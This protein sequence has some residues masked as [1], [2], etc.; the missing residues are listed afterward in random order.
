MHIGF[1]TGPGNWET[2]RR[3]VIEDAPPFCELWFNILK[4]EE[5]QEM[6]DWLVRH[7]VKIGLH[8]WGLCRDSIKTNLATA[9]ADIRAESIRQVKATI[10]I[11]AQIN[12]V[13]VNAHPGAGY[14]EKMDFDTRTQSRLSVQA[15]SPSRAFFLLLE[16]AR[17]LHNYA[18]D[19]GVVLT[20]E[21]L[22]GMENEYYE[23]RQNVY[24]PANTSLETMEQL[25]AAGSYIA[26]DLTH[27]SAFIH[28]TS[29]EPDKV[30]EMLRAFTRRVQ[31]RIRLLHV[32]TIAPPFNGTDSH[33][34][35]LPEDFA[36]GVFPT[37]EQIATL[38][39]LF[40]D[41]D[42]VYCIPEPHEKMQENFHVLR[43]LAMLASG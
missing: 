1:K 35:L 37:R 28:R 42:D 15:T 29:T 5:Y 9:V 39:T 4:A 25:A 30:F 34:G 19:R 7:Q 26:N 31:A 41:R 33:H 18:R 27:T 32:N 10:D 20:L 21:T 2:A 13:Y 17:E 36:Q 23:L 6:I 38:L 16:A 24:D 43:D 14:L 22:P 40:K 12:C 8:H 11:G 3:I